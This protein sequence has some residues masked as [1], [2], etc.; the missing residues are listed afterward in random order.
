MNTGDSTVVLVAVN[1]A[2]VPAQN[3]AFAPATF[4]SAATAEGFIVNVIFV[5]GVVF[6][7]EFALTAST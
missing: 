7:H 5:R 1:L 2:D 6:T 3:G 4:M